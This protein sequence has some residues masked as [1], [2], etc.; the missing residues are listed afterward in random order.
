MRLKISHRTEYRY[1]EPVHYALQRLRLMPH[2]G[3]DADGACPGRSTI[4]GAREE[5]RFAD[6]F[7]N[8]T[9]LVSVEGE[10]DVDHA[11]RRR[12]R[13]RPTTRP[14]LSGRIRASRRSGCSSQRRR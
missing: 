2:S 4:E 10:R 5:V 1:D 6:H 8:D 13:S 11:S 12:A 3:H 9:R 14:A 7:G